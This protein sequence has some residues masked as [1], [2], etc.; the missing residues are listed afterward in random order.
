[1]KRTSVILVI[2]IALFVFAGAAMAQQSLTHPAKW[3]REL[4]IFSTVHAGTTLI[5]AG[6]YKIRH[7]M[8]GQK[9]IM[10]FTRVG[11]WNE[12]YRVAC[13][14]VPL[15]RKAKVDEQHTRL[16]KVGETELLSLTFRG[17]EVIHEFVQ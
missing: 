6:D 12:Q 15:P 11:K 1:M 14:M 4:T 8:D 3:N 7:E 17:D 5:P 16:G 2:I 10:I 9:H 13:D